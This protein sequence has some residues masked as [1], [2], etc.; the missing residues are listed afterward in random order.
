[1]GKPMARARIAK[2]ASKLFVTPLASRTDLLFLVLFIAGILAVLIPGMFISQMIWMLHPAVMDLSQNYFAFEYLIS[3]VVAAAAFSA[4]FVLTM[5]ALKSVGID[6]D[7]SRL[8]VAAW[9]QT[10]VCV[11]VMAIVSQAFRLGMDQLGGPMYQSAIMAL[12]GM[13]YVAG[14]LFARK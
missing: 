12:F 13:S 1:M 7:R 4:I 10:L 9:L 11:A 2:N 6:S 8:R 3:M 14:A 5:V